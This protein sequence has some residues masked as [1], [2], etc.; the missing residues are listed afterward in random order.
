MQ[1]VS[2]SDPLSTKDLPLK[3][4]ALIVSA[5]VGRNAVQPDTVPTL[6]RAVYGTLS[7]I[8]QPTDIADTEARTPAVPVKRSVFPDYIVCLEDGKK[9]KMLRRHLSSAYGMTPAQ[10]RERWRLPSNYPMVAPNYATRQSELAR[11]SGL[12]RKTGEDSA[13]AV[14]AGAP[15]IPA[16]VES[17][18]AQEDTPRITVLPERKRGRRKAPV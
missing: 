10:Y 13:G 15:E 7:S 8:G 18:S 5:Y 6:I 3:L 14:S 17:V 1:S 11:A 16:P 2:A 9:L 4:T 12:G